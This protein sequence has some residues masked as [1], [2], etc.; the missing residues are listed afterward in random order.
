MAKSFSF[1]KDFCVPIESSMKRAITSEENIH[2]VAEEIA[3]PILKDATNGKNLEYNDWSGNLRRSYI[4]RVTSKTEYYLFKTGLGV[5]P[6]PIVVESRLKLRNGKMSVSQKAYYFRLRR[7]GKKGVFT[8]KNS[9]IYH[10]RKVSWSVFAK[11]Q[12]RK[13]DRDRPI[14]EWDSRFFS[15]KNRKEGLVRQL[16]PIE[17][18]IATN[19]RERHQYLSNIP[20]GRARKTLSVLIG[21]YAPY[22]HSVE[23]HGKQVINMK[24]REKYAR[25]IKDKAMEVFGRATNEICMQINRGQ[26]RDLKTGRFIKG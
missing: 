16:R 2:K 19:P 10:K 17:S 9:Y 21:N 1:V 11:S 26:L 25:L 4:V 3:E 22:S 23:K 6:R 13:D 12:N 5:S 24:S 15:Y 8:G 18:E 14:R 20:T 7:K